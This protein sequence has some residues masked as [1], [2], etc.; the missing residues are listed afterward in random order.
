MSA[1]AIILAAGKGARIGGTPKQFRLL[2]GRPLVRYCAESFQ[3]AGF[4][5][6]CVV[7]CPPEEQYENEARNALSDLS[8]IRIFTSGGKRRRDSVW[9]GLN[10]LPEEAEYVLIHDGA[11][12]F[13]PMEATASALESARQCGA[14]ILGLPAMDTVKRADDN[15]F[16]SDTLDR[17]K[18][19]LIQTPQV[20]RKDL[21]VT[22]LK[23]NAERNLTDDA[24]AVELIGGKVRLVHGSRF[25]IK[26]TVA[27]D[28]VIA[29]AVLQERREERQV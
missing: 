22:A 5:E 7:V 25:N 17:S 9:N 14:A 1:W 11:R 27:E 4:I 16:V 19:W 18:L 3:N 8:K 26:V 21:I 29:R 13:P 2:Q 12:P 23:N 10:S 15:Q 6:G 24:S 28:F 20:F